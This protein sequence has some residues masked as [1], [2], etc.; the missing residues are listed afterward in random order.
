MTR[1][2]VGYV[3]LV[4]TCPRCSTKN[5]GPQKFCNGCGGPQPDNVQFEQAAQEKLLT[6]AGAISRAKAGP[7]IH[8]PYCGA[9]NPAGVKFCGSCG[10]NLAEGLARQ[11]GRV[12]GA[13]RSGPAPKVKCPACGTENA[14]DAGRCS[15]CGS[16]LPG[17]SR[18]AASA[19]A[20]APARRLPVPL[21]AVGGACLLLGALALYLLTGKRDTVEAAVTSVHW[22]R[23]IAIEALRPVEHED[24]RDQVPSQATPGACH[25]E[26][27]DT[28]DSQAPNSVEVCGTP[29]TVDLGNGQA[30]IVT[31]CYYEI[32]DDKCSYTLNEWTAIDRLVVSGDALDPIWPSDSNLAAGERPGERGE[33]YEVVLT[34]DGKAYTY[35][36]DS[37]TE[38]F[39]FA[40]ASRWLLGINALGGIL[41]IEPAP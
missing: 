39:S 37:E 35:S 40:P 4:W 13:F 25:E 21:L 20:T 5:P 17:T 2:T 32:Y 8:C 36:P 34:A 14:A 22:E 38:F 23:T 28:Q 19:P 3:E 18:E 41:T 16:P 27:R 15:N 29:Y 31:D 30:E 7:D 1:K 24:W 6:D 12:L 33:S 11:K 10:G 9:R 26:V